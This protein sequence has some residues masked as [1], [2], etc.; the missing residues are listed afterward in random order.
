VR[1]DGRARTVRARLIVNATGVWCDELRR[2]R[3][4]GAARLVRPS[5]GV[6]LVFSR[7]RLKVE[8]AAILHSPED[9]RIVFLVPA[10]ERVIVGTTDTDYDGDINRPK[11]ENADV[12]YLLELL[13]R[14]LPFA[15]LDRRDLV[16][17]YAGLRPLLNQA[18]DSPSKVSRDHQIL[19]EGIV[20]VTGG[21][22][23]TYR[24]MARQVVD[25]AARKLGVPGKSSTHRI[26]LY[27]AEAADDPL[28]RQYGSEATSIVERRPLVDGLPYVEGELEYAVTHEMAV[29]LAD[30]LARRMRIVLFDRDQGRG[31]AERVA[32]RLAPLAGWNVAREVEA[33]ERELADYPR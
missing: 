13:R 3:S 23:T 22:L 6:H 2:R 19:D 21:K 31:I 4:E 11:A 14:H 7:D 17:T 18:A 28:V 16:S 24:L 12:D 33:F 15:A 27:A 30:V 1:V 8:A 32:R 5:K 9:G 25:L 26:P 10:G 29:T 20:T